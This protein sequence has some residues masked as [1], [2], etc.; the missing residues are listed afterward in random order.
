MSGQ[1]S[2][3]SCQVAV[4]L[5]DFPQ[6]LSAT[7]RPR[8]RS[9][10][11]SSSD[12]ILLLLTGR[13]HTI[14]VHLNEGGAAIATAVL[15]TAAAALKVRPGDQIGLKVAT[16]PLSFELSLT[17]HSHFIEIIRLDVDLR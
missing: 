6:S 16:L 17:H 14:K 8:T 9:G 11:S 2:S 5:I 15:S 7:S 3:S 12:H 4:A 1:V 13:I 10:R